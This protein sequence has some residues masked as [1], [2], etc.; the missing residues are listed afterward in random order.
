M[1]HALMNFQFVFCDTQ[2]VNTGSVHVRVKTQ[3]GCLFWQLL[4]KCEKT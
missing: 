3:V 1:C 2:I 4:I